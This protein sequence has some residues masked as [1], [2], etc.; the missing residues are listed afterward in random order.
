V[1]DK[2]IKLMRIVQRNLGVCLLCLHPHSQEILCQSCENT[3]PKMEQSHPKVLFAYQDPLS[4]FMVSLKFHQALYFANW[5]AKKMIE[6]WDPPTVDCIIAL[7]LHPKRQ[8]ERGFNQ[9]LEIAKVLS[10]HWK[11]PL[12][13]WSARRIRYRKAQ[14]SLTASERKKNVTPSAFQID[15]KLKGKR[16]LVIEDV[17][18]TGTTLKAFEQALKL[19]GVKEVVIWACCQALS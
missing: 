10:K 8:Q 17:I 1:L 18:T 7:P 6:R 19:V 5:F 13:K 4:Y 14:S 11:I 3:F 9:T 12:D 15:P 16:V 2:L